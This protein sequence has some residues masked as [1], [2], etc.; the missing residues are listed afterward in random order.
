MTSEE[1]L[2]ILALKQCKNIGNINLKKLLNHIGSAKQVWHSQKKSLLEISGIGKNSIQD[3][4]NQEFL[5]RAEKELKFCEKQGISIIS[6]NE[7]LYPKHLLNCEDAPILLFY[8]GHLNNDS[9]PISIVGTRKLTPYGKHF[10]QDLMV[11]LSGTK[12]CTVSGLALGAD[13]CVHEESLKNQIPTTAVLAQSLDKIYPTSNKN[14]SKR[15]LEND[16][17]L[18]TEYASFDGMSK[19]YFLQRNRV[20]AGLSLQLIVVETA[21]GGGSVST[22]TAANNYNR[23][24]YALPGKITDIFSQG[25]NQLIAMNKAE[26]IVNIKSLIENLNFS[27]QPELFPK[28]KLKIVLDSSKVEHQKV[29]DIIINE[30]TISLDDI[31]EKTDILHHKLL[32]ILLDLEIYGC[33]K[34]LSGRQY[35]SN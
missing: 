20:I 4:G 23:D 5:M 32:P 31:A 28:E 15:I 13:T 24:V 6:Q 25:C 22:V 34:C 27:L 29:L 2:Y 1:L 14:L 33:I 19:E 21:Y 10:I 11:E 16:G 18:I 9:N 12:V 26:T 17:A 7:K 35:Q 3:I 8:K 30:N